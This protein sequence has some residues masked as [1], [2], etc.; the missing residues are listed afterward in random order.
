MLIGIIG[1]GFVGNALQKSFEKKKLKLCL[2]DKYKN[3]GSFE[4][5]LNSDI[6]FLALPTNLNDKKLLDKKDLISTC[7]NLNLN[8]YSGIIVIKSTVE[9]NTTDILAQNFTDLTFVHNPEFL[10]ARTAEFDFH[11]Q[12][13]IVLGKAITCSE[14]KLIILSNFYKKYYP[15]AEISVCSS[16]ESESMKIFCNTFY[17]VKIQFFNELYDFCDK[18]EIDFT[19]VRDLMLKNNWINPMHTNVPGFDG[20]LSY[21][22]MCLP[23][24]SEAL[25]NCM[26]DLNSKYSILE[27][28]INERKTMRKDDEQMKIY[29][30]EAGV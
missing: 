26:K 17:A 12:K 29:S 9:P 21:G 19:N 2:Y 14:N 22:G 15:E 11:N 24:D 5:I 23:K 3:I 20:K 10:S 27:A 1:I 18:L 4:K 7:N 6:L 30:S 25:L 8:G 28:T 16:I 13:H